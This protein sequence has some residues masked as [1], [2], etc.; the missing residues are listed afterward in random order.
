MAATVSPYREPG[1]QN[2][3]VVAGD[4][5]AKVVTTERAYVKGICFFATGGN[6]LTQ[7]SF[8]VLQD[9]SNQ[10]YA[11]IGC[12]STEVAS[13]K[14]LWFPEAIL[15]NGINCDIGPAA[16]NQIAVIYLE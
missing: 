14:E 13:H 15:L 9:S 1:C 11:K 6:D 8:F 5:T 7:D 16:G 12:A 2:V 3:I 4:E 10:E